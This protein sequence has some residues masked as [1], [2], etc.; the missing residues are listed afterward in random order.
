MDQYTSM[1]EANKGFLAGTATKID[2]LLHLQEYDQMSTEQML[3]ELAELRDRIRTHLKPQR[4]I[5]P[6]SAAMIIRKRLK[7]C[8]SWLGTEREC[9]ATDTV[10]ALGFLYESLKDE[11]KE[12]A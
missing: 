6:T 5:K 1:A 9:S 11:A 7:L 12:A 2:R 8:F 4:C 3:D 10:D